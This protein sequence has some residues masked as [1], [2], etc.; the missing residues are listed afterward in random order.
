[1]HRWHTHKVNQPQIEK[2]NLKNACVLNMY[3]LFFY[4]IISQTI[5]NNYVGLTL[6]GITNNQGNLKY[7][8]GYTWVICGYNNI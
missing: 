5:Q 3:G 6:L 8:G 7:R 2:I 1:M 4:I